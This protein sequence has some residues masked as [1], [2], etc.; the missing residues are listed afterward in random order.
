MVGLFLFFSLPRV[1]I[2]S[3]RA[4]APR[5]SPAAGGRHSRKNVTGRRVAELHVRLRDKTAF[6]KTRRTPEARRH[7]SETRRAVF[8]FLFFTFSFPVRSFT[9]IRVCLT[10]CYHTRRFLGITEAHF[11]FTPHACSNTLSA[12]HVCVDPRI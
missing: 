11:D 3:R 5:F 6:R 12:G 8:R 10:R 4:I 9:I 7:K 2:S 1:I